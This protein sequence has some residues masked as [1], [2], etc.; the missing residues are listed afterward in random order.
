MYYEMITA[1]S[2]VSFCHH[3]QLIFDSVVKK[4]SFQF[5]FLQRKTIDFFIVIFF[6]WLEGVLLKMFNLNHIAHG[7]G[8]K[9]KSAK[10]VLNCKAVYNYCLFMLLFKLVSKSLTSCIH[11]TMPCWDNHLT[12]K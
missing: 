11:Q 8:T 5:C 6:S 2:L 9:L 3:T 1:V 10:A 7:M 12:L 4:S